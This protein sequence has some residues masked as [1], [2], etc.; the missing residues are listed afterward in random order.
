MISIANAVGSRDLGV[1]LDV[2][3]VKSDL[4]LPYT[5]YNPSNYH[6]LY[7]RLVADGPLITVYR[8]GKYIISGCSTLEQLYE[9][10]GAFLTAL[11]E[12]DIVNAETETRFKVQNVVCTAQLDDPVDLNTLS[13][14]LGLESVEYEPEQ[15]PGLIY[16]PADH[17]AVL[18]VFANGKIVI[19]GGSDVATAED[20]F[21]HLQEQV[22]TYLEE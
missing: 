22:M 15:F 7:L 13:V 16:R 19:T 21:K 2:A 5:E 17:P 6:G 8:S 4:D 11:S 14:A 3:E 20:A 9:T 12:L 1:E 10:N 18:L